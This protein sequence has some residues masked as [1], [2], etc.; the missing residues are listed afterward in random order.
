MKTSE[1]IKEDT[2]CLRDFVL[3]LPIERRQSYLA[4]LN[5]L[6]AAANQCAYKE[7]LLHSTHEYLTGEWEPD[8]I[9]KGKFARWVMEEDSDG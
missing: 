6:E 1:K 2:G 7:A 3:S 8:D 5:S 4:I 9:D